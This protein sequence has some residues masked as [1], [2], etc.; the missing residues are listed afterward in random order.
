MSF[1]KN[2]PYFFI[3]FLVFANFIL[4]LEI[5]E[6]NILKADPYNY[7]RLAEE[8]PYIWD[9]TFP[10]FYPI[11]IKIVHFF[12]GDYFFSSK[13][14]AVLSIAFVFIYS[15]WK[16]FYWRE[17]WVIISTVSFLKTNFWT[18][19][20]TL[21]I[22]LLVIFSYLSY[23]YLNKKVKN[24]RMWLGQFSM[25]LI[26]MCATKY[27]SIF[28]VAAI[29][30]YVFMYFLFKRKILYPLLIAS[31]ICT[32]FVA[33]YLFYNHYLTG[34]YTGPRSSTWNNTQALNIQS[35]LFHTFYN[36]NP[37]INSR[38]VFGFKINYFLLF[39]ISIFLYIPLIINV[40]R[41][42]L[43]L[44]SFHL[45]F[46]S[47]SVIFLIF[48]LLSYFITKIDDL[49]ARLVLPFI[50]FLFLTVSMLIKKKEYLILI[51]YLSLILTFADNIYILNYGPSF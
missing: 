39:F 45:Y 32:V 27:S 18:R 9:T 43:I 25:I 10:V 5:S 20:E 8:F 47:M 50:F 14:V 36:M 7:L 44:K 21:L 15:Y 4:F 31:I 48:T 34:Y 51:A 19:S 23:Q 11:V 46:L 26:L 28:F 17:I 49:N 35:S 13:V 3:P 30:F 22:P 29:Y 2:L 6:E 37:V 42:K 41:G 40:L 12:G 33:A 38:I 1:L 16:D 24:K